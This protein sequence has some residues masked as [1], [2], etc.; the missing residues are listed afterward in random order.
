M[1]PPLWVAGLVALPVVF[2]RRGGA[3]VAQDK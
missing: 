3:A 1:V 2:L